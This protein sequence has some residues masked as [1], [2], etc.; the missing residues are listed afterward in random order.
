[1]PW[2]RVLLLE[3]QR[4]WICD[5]RWFWIRDCEIYMYQGKDLGD[6]SS[7]E[8]K[9]RVSRVDSEWWRVQKC[10]SK[11]KIWWNS[12][13]VSERWFCEPSLLLSACLQNRILSSIRLSVVSRLRFWQ[14]NPFKS[15]LQCYVSSNVTFSSVYIFIHD[16]TSHSI[17]SRHPLA[18]PDFKFL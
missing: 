5:L 3:I 12:P 7:E 10:K 4:A 13:Y 15:F 6:R 11:G 16:E 14:E 1:M 8:T 2:V 17:P 18:W 9:M